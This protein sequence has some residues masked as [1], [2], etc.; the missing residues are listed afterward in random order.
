MS[1]AVTTPIS[2]E[3]RPLTLIGDAKLSP[4]SMS[5][6]AY[7]ALASPMPFGGHGAHHVTIPRSWVDNADAKARFDYSVVGFSAPAG[8][9]GNNTEP[10]FGR[11]IIRDVDGFLVAYSAL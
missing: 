9:T 2:P 11:C 7:V 3:G 6:V 1:T 8:A 10:D 5:T 4:Y